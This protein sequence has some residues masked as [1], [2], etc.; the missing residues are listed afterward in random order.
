MRDKVYIC[1]SKADS[2]APWFR[3]IV[4]FLRVYIHHGLFHLV[5]DA[6][7]VPGEAVSEQQHQLLKTAQAAVLLLSSEL[8]AQTDF[9]ER[10][11]P[12]LSA[13]MED[14]L[15]LIPV[16]LRP[17]GADV[18]NLDSGKR[19]GKVITQLIGANRFEEPLS[20]HSGN[21]LEEVLRHVV[22][23]I[24]G[25]AVQAALEPA[26][27]P[28]EQRLLQRAFAQAVPV[29]DARPQQVGEMLR[30]LAVLPVS[31]EGRLPI[32]TFLHSLTAAIE[33][34][35]KRQHIYDWLG[36]RP[37]FAPGTLISAQ[38]GSALSLAAAQLSRE[39]PPPGSPR[40]SLLIRI[41]RHG[42]WDDEPA[43]SP[44][45]AKY[46][47][48]AW[49]LRPKPDRSEPL[50]GDA[51]GQTLAQLREGPMLELFLKQA[52]RH[53]EDGIEDEPLVV[54]F[55][56]PSELLTEAFDQWP[57]AGF[58]LGINYSVAVRW[59][60]GAQ[61]P[62]RIRRQKKCWK[63]LCDIWNE[64]CAV[65]PL[66]A[67]A[68]TAAAAAWLGTDCG[69]GVRIITS[70]EKGPVVCAVLESTRPAMPKEVL[71]SVL[72]AG[73]PVALWARNSSSAERLK[74]LVDGACL[75]G[76]PGRV[77]S[78]RQEG[79]SSEEE[80]HPGRHLTLLWDDPTRECPDFVPLRNPE[81]RN[82]AKP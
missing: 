56:V 52:S 73:V 4:D 12:M 34:V 69:A 17:S 33:H 54:E 37:L 57:F 31:S 38:G 27:H 80:S 20:A 62:H 78:E 11:L 60:E 32:V 10:M 66:A 65:V 36:R 13:M 61:Y 1:W 28:L 19:R 75:G 71:T 51:E 21:Q 81:Q 50:V 49:I 44:E 53:T 67:I 14:G 64:R 8:L 55:M 29:S 76:L 9:L 68:E 16:Y 59:L 18:V 77:L 45:Q 30:Q 26:L 39:P 35:D 25:R 42:A 6:D 79:S 72:N 63:R 48:R 70:L 22:K 58:P 3:R 7:I 40:P 47:C 23:S 43:L 5:D 82:G 41:E 15:E 24:Y 74:G 46:R 2:D